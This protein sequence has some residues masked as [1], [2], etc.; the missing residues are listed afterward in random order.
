M[1]YC[2]GMNPAKPAVDQAIYLESLAWRQAEI[3]GRLE[4]VR[5][6]VQALQKEESD[7]IQQVR[8]LD[9]LIGAAKGNGASPPMGPSS[10]QLVPEQK[11]GTMP[12]FAAFGPTAREIYQRAYDVIRDA[13]M[14]L[15]YRVLAEQVQEKVPLSGADPGATLIAHL[16][17]AQDVFPRLGRGIYGITGLVDKPSLPPQIDGAGKRRQRVRRRRMK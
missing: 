10:T 1:W 15:H 6:E 12:D 11:T 17:R 16:H 2:I 8:A 14:P 7:L 13:G 4:A 9:L 5:A 3:R